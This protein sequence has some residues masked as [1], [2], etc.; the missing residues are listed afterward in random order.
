MCPSLSEKLA[1]DADGTGR[2]GVSSPPLS[3]Q[4]ALPLPYSGTPGKG[5]MSDEEDEYRSGKALAAPPCGPRLGAN[6]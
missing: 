1:E 3:R 2:Q 5:G 4:A 6:D